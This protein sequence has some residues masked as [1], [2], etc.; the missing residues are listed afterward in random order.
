MGITIKT[1]DVNVSNADF[2]PVSETKT[3]LYGLGSIKGVGESAIPDI[4][5]NRPYEGLNDMLQRIPKKS[6]NKRVGI[7]LIKSGACKEFADNRV[8]L[9]NDFYTIRKD[10][11]ELLDITTWSDN[12]CMEYET[13]TLGA[14]ITYKPWWDVVP[15]DNETIEIVC[16]IKKVYEKVD[17]NG[18][19]MGFVTVVSDGCTIETVVFARQYCK[20]SDKFE[21]RNGIHPTLKLRGK[22]DSKN[23]F[24]VSSVKAA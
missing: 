24:I 15:V 17:R 7:A 1:P 23:K 13:D 22:K 6:I 11:D 8:S 9:I 14:P 18:N 20:N 2:T 12:L 4:I 3:I 19:M 5:A 10:K 16:E 21:I